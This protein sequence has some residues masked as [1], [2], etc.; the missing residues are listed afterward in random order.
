M[1]L[2]MVP[3]CQADCYMKNL[4]MNPFDSMPKT[5][6]DILTNRSGKRGRD[7]KSKFS[8][9]LG[10][11]K[12]RDRNTE[13]IAAENAWAATWDNMVDFYIFEYI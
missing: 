5:A 8:T 1:N 7:R 3:I 6:K 10:F 13:A 11:L 9:F 4:S 12:A 2:F